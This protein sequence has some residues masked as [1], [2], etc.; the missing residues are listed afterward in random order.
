M[1]RALTLRL[2]LPAV[3][4]PDRIE[5]IDD[6]V[7]AG[8]QRARHVRLED[9]KVGHEPR[10]DALPVDPMVLRSAPRPRAG[11]R[12][13]GNSR[14]SRRPLR[15]PAAA[16]CTSR[17]GCAPCCR[18]ARCR[19][20]GART[21][22]RRCAAWCGRRDPSKSSEVCFTKSRKRVSSSRCRW[23]PRPAF[24]CSKR[25][26]SNHAPLIASHISVVKRDADRAG[27]GAGVGDAIAD[28]RRIVRREGQVLDDVRL[29][30]A[31]FRSCGSP[32]R[33]RTLRAR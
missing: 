22:R 30:D 17:R 21:S 1:S 29:V 11:S 7:V 2:A 8:D 28:R 5:K 9:Q 4:A 13:T 26:S 6:V 25:I 32:R 31:P 14:A 20:P 19:R 24:I 18:R 3:G 12:S 33:R 23:P 10:L 15:S 27:V 16:R